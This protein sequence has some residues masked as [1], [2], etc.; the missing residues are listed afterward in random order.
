M[1]EQKAFKKVQ[2]YLSIIQNT[3]LLCNTNEELGTLVDYPSVASGNGLAR[4]GGKSLFM[5]N[6]I[7]SGLAAIALQRTGLDL[8]HLLDTY[9]EADTL[10]NAI[11]QRFR[12]EET[13]RHLVNFFFADGHQTGD[14][15]CIAGRAESRHVPLLLLMLLQVLP[16]TSSRGGDVKDITACY[17]RVLA[18][19]GD[20][21]SKLIFMDKLPALL[22]VEHE[23]A[24]GTCE[25]NRLH[26]IYVT[27]LVLCAYGSVLSAASMGEANIDL[28]KNQFYPDVEGIWTEDEDS[29]VFWRFELISNG[30]NL[31]RYVLKRT[32]HRL[33]YIKYFARFIHDEDGDVMIVV[34]PAAIR[35]LVSGTP[36]PNRMVAYLDCATGDNDLSFSLKP[37]SEKWFRLKRLTRSKNAAYF[38]SLLKDDR[39]RRDNECGLDEYEF[40]LTLT[41]ITAD[42]IYIQSGEGGYYRV[43]K[44]L[45]EA[46]EQVTFD[47][48]VGVI[49]FEDSTYVAF[50][51][52]RLYYDVTN[53]E[54]MAHSGISLVDVIKA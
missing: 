25:R 51:D 2:N 27:D 29:T 17:D 44:S 1:D 40:N 6:A 48:N 10:Y 11:P 20:L 34:H 47:S 35:Y 33:S 49:R 7:F 9:Q 14:I 13:C 38:E 8:R 54:K 3:R 12:N 15:G 37:V 19:L 16:R 50:D 46:L 30:F 41:A 21:T 32:E 22:Q 43:P 39:Y 45:N 5:K 24:A 4:M 26:L 18:F 31:Y 28:L 42:Y 53:E 36:L 23:L 52:H